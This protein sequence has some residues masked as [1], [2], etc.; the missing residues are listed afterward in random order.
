M[1]KLICHHW[2]T[3]FILRSSNVTTGWL[4]SACFRY[5]RF[6]V[7][8]GDVPVQKWPLHK[9]YLVIYFNTH[10]KI[11]LANIYRKLPEDSTQIWNAMYYIHFI[12]VSVQHNVY[13]YIGSR[14]RLKR[15]LPCF[16]DG[17]WHEIKRP[18]RYVH[19]SYV[20]KSIVEGNQMIT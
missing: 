9:V 20:L 1:A 13:H 11:I 3:I 4:R 18:T 14:I 12:I 5:K 16:V 15:L 6:M 8:T 2:S 19:I 17:P 10:N 7:I